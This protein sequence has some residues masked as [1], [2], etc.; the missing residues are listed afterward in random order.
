MNKSRLARRLH[1]VCQ[2][3]IVRKNIEFELFRADNA[4]IDRAGMN[5]DSHVDF[6][7][8]VLVEFFDGI[9][10]RQAHE[11]AGSCVIFTR[12]GTTA[13]AIVAIAERGDFLARHLH[14]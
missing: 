3:H 4:A 7:V 14:A 8:V 6:F 2:G 5:A 9:D 13:H 10:H 1:F 11:Y 12:L